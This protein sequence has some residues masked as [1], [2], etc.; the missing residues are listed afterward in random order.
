MSGLFASA[1]AVLALAPRVLAAGD[2]HAADDVDSEAIELSRR[3]AAADAASRS[4]AVRTPI[5]VGTPFRLFAGL[6]FGRGIRFNNPYRLQTEL[7]DDAESLSLTAT[8]TDL[9]AGLA[10]GGVGRFSHGGA[11]NAS[12][13]LDGIPQQV[14]T[15][16]YVL[17]YRLDQRFELIGR[18][19]IP[20]VLAPDSNVGFELAAGG[21]YRLT[22]ALGL[23]ASLVGSLFYGAATLETSRT[24]IPI[25][26]LELGLR[27]EYEVLP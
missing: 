21:I 11:L 13:A 22:A 8:Y 5:E 6:S 9:Q 7:G 27:Y 1:L 20:V 16:S 12:F 17:L 23:T 18:A 3:Q 25:A 2:L 19:G 26:S 10:F 4:S 24:T 14:L 15:P